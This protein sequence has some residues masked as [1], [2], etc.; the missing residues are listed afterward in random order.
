[1]SG[2]GGRPVPFLGADRV[3]ACRRG[4]TWREIATA[5]VLVV[6][7]VFATWD[8]WWDICDIAA[9]DE[10][11]SHAFLVPVVAAYLLWVRRERLRG[12]TPT[13][14]WLGP[15]MV[16]AGWAIH[17]YGDAQLVQTLWHGG[18][19]LV[20]TGAFLTV[21]GAGFLVRCFPAFLAL[22]F[23]VP[24]PNMVRQA[25]SIP[26]QGATAEVTRVVL[27]TC[28]AQ[29][30]RSGNTLRINDQDVLIAEACNGLRMVFALVLVSYT[31]AFGSPL[32]WGF[33]ALV[34][35]GSPL[36]AI[37]FNVIRLVPTV[38]AFGALPA[39]A[40]TTLH[41]MSGWLMLPFAFLT[42]VVVLRMLRWAQVPIT[43]FVLAHGT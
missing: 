3:T 10:E 25:V 35:F 23:L 38:W 32:R 24:V 6:V 17:G 1:V 30:E 20:V 5:S 2:R 31:F 27:E 9:R 16:A 13:G 40:A 12:Y 19:I 4:W 15:L 39:S 37:A 28:G 26:L 7:A 33:R 43:P 8:A 36:T 21:A 22:C 34:V 18:A 41:D 42:L 29:V 14:T 11:H